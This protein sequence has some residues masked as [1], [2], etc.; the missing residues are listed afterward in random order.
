MRCLRLRPNGTTNAT[1]PRAL[2]RTALFGCQA[3]SE[4]LGDVQR[5][6]DFDKAGEKRYKRHGLHNTHRSSSH[7]TDHLSQTP[8]GWWLGLKIISDFL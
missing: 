8:A 5:N 7:R 3:V 4:G 1:R 6:C 2:R